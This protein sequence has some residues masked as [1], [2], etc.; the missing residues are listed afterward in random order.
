MNTPWDKPRGVFTKNTAKAVSSNHLKIWNVPIRK[1]HYIKREKYLKKI[2]DGFQDRGSENVYALIG[3]AGIGKTQ[4]AKEYA[5]AYV[6]DYVLAM[7]DIFPRHFLLLMIL[8]KRRY[9][10]KES[11]IFSLPKHTRSPLT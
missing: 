4:L 1:E 3:M 6:K 11:S 5:H 10:C 7:S 9:C 2:K 8:K